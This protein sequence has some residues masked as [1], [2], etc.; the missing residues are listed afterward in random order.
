MYL[1]N[2]YILDKPYTW[3]RGMAAGSILGP[4]RRRPTSLLYYGQQIK[5]WIYNSTIH[6]QN[7]LKLVYKCVNTICI[8]LSN[9]KKNCAF[10]EDITEVMLIFITMKIWI[11]MMKSTLQELFSIRDINRIINVT[12]IQRNHKSVFSFNAKKKFLP[13]KWR[14]SVSCPCQGRI[15]P[16]C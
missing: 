7:V 6:H 11:V 10:T 3:R 2:F 16:R 13:W 15:T 1:H 14:A 8:G 9:K 12:D 5:K 4:L